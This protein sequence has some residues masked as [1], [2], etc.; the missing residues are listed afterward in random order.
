MFKKGSASILETVSSAGGGNR[1]GGG[2]SSGDSTSECGR[3][4]VAAAS[5]GAGP[6]QALGP[7]ATCPGEAAGPAERVM[8]AEEM[9]L[10]LERRVAAIISP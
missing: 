2:S 6:R 9:P 8:Q 10:R 1:P 4:E 7:M 5:V 3:T